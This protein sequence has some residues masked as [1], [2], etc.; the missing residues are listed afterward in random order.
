V[1]CQDQGDE[2]SR[3]C[4][5]QVGLVSAISGLGRSGQLW[6]G[7]QRL[8]RLVQLGLAHAG[9]VQRRWLLRQAAQERDQLRALASTWRG[10]RPLGDETQL[11]QGIVDQQGPGGGDDILSARPGLVAP[12]GL[13]WQG[14][15]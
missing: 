7:R 4:L 14:L 3:Y 2:G 10:R 11:E 5:D 13:R 12:G 1:P 9:A 6:R 15:L 8:D